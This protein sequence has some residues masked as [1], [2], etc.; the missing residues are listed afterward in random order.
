MAEH[1]ITGDGGKPAPP[2][3]RLRDSSSLI[4]GRIILA[5]FFRDGTII[6]KAENHFVIMN[7]Q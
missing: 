7:P 4:N 1:N 2:V 5:P 3:R 6:I